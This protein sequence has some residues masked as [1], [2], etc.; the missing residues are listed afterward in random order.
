VFENKVLRRI[1]GPKREEVIGAWRKLHTEEL[2]NL[3]TSPCTV[4]VIK[5]RMKWVRH[6]AYIKIKSAY[7]IRVRTTREEV[8][9]EM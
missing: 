9:W 3:Y 1:Y 2:H 6:V 4:G 5:S 7:K 8:T